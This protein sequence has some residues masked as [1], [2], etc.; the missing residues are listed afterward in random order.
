MKK[1]LLTTEA[2]DSIITRVKNLSVNHQPQWGEMTASEMLLHCNSCNRQILQESGENKKTTLK[3]YLLRILALY[4]A[5]DFKKNI[6][7]ESR[8]DTKGKINSAEFE[9]QRTEFIHLITQFPANTHSLTLPHPAF[10]NISTHE[11][12]IAAY[13]HMDHHLRQFGV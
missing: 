10:G 13:K 6:L 12:G 2:S 8:H 3:Q 9:K 11:W 4:I 7:G 1:N 5:S